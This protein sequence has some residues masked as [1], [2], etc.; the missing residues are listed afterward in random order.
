MATRIIAIVTALLGVTMCSAPPQ[1]AGPPAPRLYVFENGFIRGLD[2]MLF[3]L[4]RDQVKEPDFVNTSYLIVHPRGTL[5]FESG[6]IPDSQFKGDGALI[7]DGVQS[8]NKPLDRKS[9]V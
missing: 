7:V 8:A 2:T 1:P 5:R 3:N 4:P 6:G 9:V